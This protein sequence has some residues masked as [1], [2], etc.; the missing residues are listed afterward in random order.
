MACAELVG[1]AGAR[2][3]FGG[4]PLFLNGANVAWVDY[5]HDANASAA[6]GNGLTTICGW[7]A[8]IRFVAENGG[9]SVR[10][11]LFE[12]PQSVFSYQGGHVTGLREGVIEMA[13]TLL[14]VA[15]AYNVFVVLVLFNGAQ[16]IE[17]DCRLFEDTKVIHT[18][19]DEAIRPLAEALQ[20]Y[21]SL[22]MWEVINEPEA[23]LDLAT[24]EGPELTAAMSVCPGEHDSPGWNEACRLP[25]N[26]L[27]LF[28]NRMAAALHTHDGRHL[29]TLGAWH[30]CTTT[31]GLRGSVNLFSAERLR[32]AGS[33]P[34]G[35]IDVYQV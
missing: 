32:E 7:D 35:T 9:N 12:Q 21:N 34:H 5:G 22:A 2:L 17:K 23:L 28:V 31:N 29:V 26:S 1:A 8:A 30:Y 15:A 11:W 33:M 19:V 10:A 16:V 27:L 24:V 4:R 3:E 18:L 20:P 25:L 14:E 6:R 13:K